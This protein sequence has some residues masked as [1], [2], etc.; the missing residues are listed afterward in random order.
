MLNCFNSFRSKDPLIIHDVPDIQDE[1]DE[2]LE[3]DFV[4]IKKSKILL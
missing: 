4:N 1:P 3:K 2:N